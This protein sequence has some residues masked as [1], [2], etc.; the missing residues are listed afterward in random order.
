M[1][2]KAHMNPINR[3]WRLAARPQGM[4]TESNF[5]L[6]EGPIP[7]PGEGE[8]VM[9]SRFL[10]VDPYMRGRMADRASYA[11][12]VAIGDVM[13]GQSAGTVVASR[14]DRFKEGD[15][16]LATIGWQEYGALPAQEARRLDPTQAPI[17]TALHVLGMPGLTAYFG[18]LDVLQARE[19][20]TIVISGAAGAVG[21]TVGQIAKVKGCRAI[22]IAG[23]DAKTRWLTEDLGFDEAINYKST[24]HLFQALRACCPD[25]IDGYFD[26]VGGP[27]TDAVIGQLALN[28]RVAICGQI[29][30]YNLDRPAPGP[31]LLWNLIVKRATIRGFLV[32][33]F[34]S[35]YREALGDLGSWVRDGKVTFKENIIEGFESMPRAFIGLFEGTNTGKQLIKI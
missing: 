22:G 27:V 18:L 33:D 4:V 1:D 13:T 5:Q 7:E 31:R 9:K 25:G 23:S 32:F 26:N 20:Q 17:S 21:S 14:S 28:A 19:G 12:P 35:R 10:T 15:S 16:V 34:E 8:I 29:S 11:E 2:S 24:P 30:Q 6:T 3:Q